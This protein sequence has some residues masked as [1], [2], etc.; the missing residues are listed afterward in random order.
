MI[1][2]WPAFTS[3]NLQAFCQTQAGNNTTSGYGTL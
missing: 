2:R 3:V 1:K